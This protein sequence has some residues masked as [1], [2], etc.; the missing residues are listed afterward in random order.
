MRGSGS[1]FLFF[2]LGICAGMIVAWRRELLGGSITLA[3]L[4]AFYLVSMIATGALPRGWAWEA[5]AAPG[6]LFLAAS[7][8]SRKGESLG[9]LIR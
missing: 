8:L 6:V 3:C 5:F 9:R 2:P 4:A 1:A 7:L